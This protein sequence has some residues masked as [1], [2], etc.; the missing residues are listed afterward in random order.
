MEVISVGKYFKEGV[1]VINND[2]EVWDVDKGG[3]AVVC[4]GVD[5][6]INISKV[7]SV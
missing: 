3:Y 4:R 6:K 7:E 1:N 2:N 5:G